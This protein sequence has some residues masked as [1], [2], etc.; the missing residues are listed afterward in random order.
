MQAAGMSADQISQAQNA[1]VQSS[2]FT[3]ALA[4]LPADLADLDWDLNVIEKIP[5]DLARNP[6]VVSFQV[7]LGAYETPLSGGGS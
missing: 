1:L 4:T 5:F 7:D 6:R 2:S 3:D